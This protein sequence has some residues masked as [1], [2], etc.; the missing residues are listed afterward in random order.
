LLAVY[1]LSAGIGKFLA[2]DT[3]VVL[4]ESHNMTMIP[5]LL[6]IAGIAQIGGSICLLFN[7]YVLACSLGF[8]VM[9]ILININLHDFWNVYEGV[10]VRHETQN[11]IKNLGVLVAFLLLAA[12]NIENNRQKKLLK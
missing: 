7:K 4:M 5:V 12:V 10:D 6:A 11:F 9:T 3:H 2:W 8:A 1:F